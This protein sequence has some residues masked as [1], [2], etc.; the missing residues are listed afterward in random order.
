MYISKTKFINYL[1]CNRFVALE[2]IHKD[3]DKAIVSFSDD[4]KLDELM[5]EENND[6]IKILIDHMYD[7]NSDDQLIK[8][9]EQTETMLPYYNEIEMITGR[10][11]DHRFKGDTIYSLNTF[12]QKKFEYAYLGYHFFC[13]L[14][15]Y[16]E[17]ENY[18]RIFE[19]KATTS[20]KF[21]EMTYKDN[22][23]HKQS[24]FSYAKDGMLMF[25]KDLKEEVNEHYELKVNQLKNRLNKSGRYIYD[26][27]YQRYVFE[28]TVKSNKKHKYYLAV[29]NSEYVHDGKTDETGNPIYS[30]DLIVFIDVSSLLDSMMPIIKHD[31][32]EVIK[33]LNDMDAQEVPLGKHCQRND[34]RQ[35]IFYPICYKKI[36]KQ[37]S[38]FTYLDSHQGFK[39]KDGMLHKRSELINQGYYHMKDIPDDWLNRKK[40]QVQKGVVQTHKPYIDKK[41]IKAAID[42]LQYP[43][44]HLDFETFPCPLPRYKGEKAY[45]QSLFQYSI[46]IERQPGVC[47]K[48]KD[49]YSYLATTH[50]DIRRDLVEHMLDVIKDD[51]GSIMAYNISFEKSRLKEMAHI[52]PKY[53]DRL[54]RMADRLVDLMYFLRGNKKMFESLGFVDNKM[55]NYYHEKLNGSFSIKKVLPIFSNLSYANMPIANGTEALVTYAKFPTMNKLTLKQKSLELLDYCKQD[56][57]AMVEILDKL[58]KIVSN[59]NG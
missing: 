33:R 48:D 32:D 52:F 55:F 8:N 13:F 44:Y 34:S 59:D 4:P 30:D 27:A 31:I 5:S 28:Q 16:Q 39:D 23:G 22:D 50:D 25:K 6:K 10:A 24:I 3:K 49:N 38:V 51:N 37:N 41:R 54:E 42:A 19:V 18:I 15:G 40:N 12:Q 46:H 17:D 9:D 47:D 2:S 21:L 20:K 35:C 56:T 45:S 14:D 43:I 53:K 26:I 1:R 29:L 36:P 7:E 57:W 11:I 58:R